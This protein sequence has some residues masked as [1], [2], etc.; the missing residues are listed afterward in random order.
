MVDRTIG[1]GWRGDVIE[2]RS[3]QTEVVLSPA[4]ERLGRDKDERDCYSIGG[5]LSFV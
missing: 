5:S 3:T 2:I 4:S 1:T